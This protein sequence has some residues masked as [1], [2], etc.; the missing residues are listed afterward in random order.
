VQEYAGA[1]LVPPATLRLELETPQGANPS[2]PG[3]GGRK[4]R[5]KGGESAPGWWTARATAG[6]VT[7]GFTKGENRRKSEADPRAAGGMF[8][9]LE[10]LLRAL[11]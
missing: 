1:T 2:R 4:G 9:T 7:A 6:E 11:G 10:E 8:A 5:S 3:Q